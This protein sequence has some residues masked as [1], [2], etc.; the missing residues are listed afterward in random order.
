[1]GGVEAALAIGPGDPF[2][3]LVAEHRLITSPAATILHCLSV[4]ES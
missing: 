3:E 1:L 2:R 4:P